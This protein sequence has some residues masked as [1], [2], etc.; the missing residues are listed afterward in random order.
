[1]FPENADAFYA[2]VIEKYT[3]Y[4]NPGLAKL[5]AFAGFGVEFYSEGCYL[6]DHEGK[7]FLD[8]LGGYGVFALGHRHP[9]VVEAVKKQLDLIALSGKAFFSKPAADLA[10]AIAEI[11]PG[12]LQYT[13]FSNSGTETVEAALKF[14]RKATGRANFVSTQGSYHGKTLGAVSVT[15]REKYKI[16]IGDLIGRVDFVEY[17]NADAL[18]AVVNQDT[19]AVII[20]PIQGEGGI[21]VPPAGYLTRI[22][23]ICTQNGALMIAD[24]VQ[25]CLGRTGAMFGVDREN[26]VPDILTMAKQLGGGIMPI[27]ATVG[28][29][30]VWEKV[31][32]ENPMFHTSTF[33]GNPLACAAGL[34]AIQVVKEEGLVEKSAEVGAFMK[35]GLQDIA[36]RQDLVV[37]ARGEGLMLG[38]EFAQDEVGE[39]CVAQMMKR[40]LCAA[41]T[42]NNPRVMRF[43]PPLIITKE[44]VEWALKTF[45]EAL[46]E[47]KEILQQFV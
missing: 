21:I 40:G 32:G 27:G 33:G 43:E 18:A 28:T 3:N 26:V 39:L 47:T 37:E 2:E 4:V 34:A 24:E 17:G 13:F 11:T 9:K 7:K 41:Y 29:L 45:E 30:E 10:E 44:Q 31:F 23:E 42:L 15:G 20:E 19:A 14:A 5:M 12:N 22:R 8:C 1:M 35:Q 46:V 38:V 25:T 36:S 16:G 6:Y